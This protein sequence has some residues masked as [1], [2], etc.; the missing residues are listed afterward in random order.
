M[1]LVLSVVPIAFASLAC[2]SSTAVKSMKA[3][4]AQYAAD[5]GVAASAATASEVAPPTPPATPTALKL[6]RTADVHIQVGSVP[7]TLLRVDSI[8]RANHAY[9]AD[10][11]LTQD[12]D[13]RN[14]A[15]VVIRVPS[16]NLDATLVALRRIGTVKTEAVTSQD[17][18]HEYA[19]LETRLAVKEQ[20]VARLRALLDTHS[21]KLTDVLRVEQELSRAITE[22]EQMKGERRYDDQVVALSTIKLSLF[23]QVPSRITQML[24]PITDALHNSLAVL[25]NSVGSII[26]LIVAIG[27][28]VLAAL[29]IVWIVPPLRR[30]FI[31]GRPI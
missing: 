17:I 8:A 21:A 12:V 3:P 11:R 23:E 2:D 24:T 29:G 28:W 14:T 26:Y 31:P 27:P 20:T 10:S 1:R 25:G 19:D 30:R 16:E 6:I 4:A 18:T 22:L 9:L 15:D 13:D 5:R 7:A